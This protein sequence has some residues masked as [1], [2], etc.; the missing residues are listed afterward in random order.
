MARPCRAPS[1][2]S[3]SRTAALM[4]A[5]SARVGARSAV[6]ARASGER[7]SHSAA[8]VRPERFGRH[9]VQ[10]PPEPVER[11]GRR[12]VYQ[13]E[14][15]GAKVRVS[16]AAHLVHHRRRHACVLELAEGLARLHAPELAAVADEHQARDVQSVRDAKQR[17][18]LRG[19]GERHL[20]DDDHRARVVALQRIECFR[21]G[22]AVGHLA[23]AGEEPLE[24]AA[25]EARLPRERACRRRRGRK[26]DDAAVT[27][28]RR[29]AAQHH[30]LAGAR[31]ALHPDRAVGAF[32]DE[33]RR[34]ALAVGQTFERV[35]GDG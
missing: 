8:A 10:I 13:V 31:V 19:A 14:H 20:V 30:R 23:R 6:P 33:P 11:L 15:R 5:R 3:P 17:P 7:R 29:H 21:I 34:G 4:S 27:G 35:V 32:K 12:P 26:A 1:V 16:L 9:L 25:P 24:C 2:S 18:R 28:E 22:H